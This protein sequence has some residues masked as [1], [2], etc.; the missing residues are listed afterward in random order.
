M[1]SVPYIVPVVNQKN[2]LQQLLVNKLKMR[3]KPQLLTTRRLRKHVLLQNNQSE[4]SFNFN[5]NTQNNNSIFK[6]D[7]LLPNNNLF[8]P[9]RIRLSLALI[10]PK[11]A[12]AAAAQATGRSIYYLYPNGFIFE[13]TCGAVKNDF[14]SIYNALLNVKTGL[15]TIEP[16]NIWGCLNVPQTQQTSLL[17]ADQQDNEKDGWI[18]LAP[19]F[20]FA[21]NA[22]QEVVLESIATV[23]GLSLEATPGAGTYKYYTG[24]CL[25]MDGFSA[26]N[27]AESF[28]KDQLLELQMELQNL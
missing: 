3:K 16:M 11:E 27:Q 5:K 23:G 21:G 4:Y 6:V 24:L 10:L 25:E 9:T 22:E 14:Y 8:I 1:K 18:E 12:T 15:S 13:T 26:F 28:S 2:A 17:N 20:V 19:R 7:V